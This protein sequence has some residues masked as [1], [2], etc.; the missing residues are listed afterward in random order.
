MKLSVGSVHAMM[1]YGKVELYFF[2]V[3]SL[4]YGVSGHLHSLTNL[5]SVKK[6]YQ[7]SSSLPPLAPQLY[8]A[9]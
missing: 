9:S 1:A 5:P 4:L 7:I 8:S 3:T 2:F 6:K